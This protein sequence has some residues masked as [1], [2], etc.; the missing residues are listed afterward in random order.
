MVPDEI[1]EQIRKGN[2]EPALLMALEEVILGWSANKEKLTNASIRDTVSLVNTIISL[3]KARS[4]GS[5]TSDK[6]DA[7]S[8]R[9][10]LVKDGG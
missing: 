4:N 8:E 1:I 5:V 9:L 6:E 10:R 2:I 7:F 3:Q